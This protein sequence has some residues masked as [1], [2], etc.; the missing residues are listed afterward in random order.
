MRVWAVVVWVSLCVLIVSGTLATAAG[1]HPG[2]TVVRRLWSFQPAVYWHVRATA[3]FGVSFALLLVWLVRHRSR[4]LRGALVVL[5]LLAV[6]M[7][8]GEIQYRTHLPWWLVLVHVTVAATVWA[9]A[10][11]FV[12]RLWR[13]GGPRRMS[14]M[15]DELRIDERPAARAPGAGRGVPRLERRRPGRVAR[16]RVPRARLGGRRFA[17]IDPEGFYDFQATRPTVSLVDGETRRIDWPENHFLLRAA[18]GRRARRDHPARRRAEP[19]LAH[20]LGARHAA[21][22]VSSRSSS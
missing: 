21:S 6:Q 5:G 14:S 20:V 9:A 18:A 11:A 10:T 3:V 15:T 8:I 22:R 19:A 12:Y 1:P 2:S 16:R 4:H 17:E 13:P 7:T